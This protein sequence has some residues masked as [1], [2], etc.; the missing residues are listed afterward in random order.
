MV[1]SA[2][3]S[4]KQRLGHGKM[5]ANQLKIKLLSED[6]FGRICQNDAFLL[7]RVSGLARR[8]RRSY[9]PYRLSSCNGNGGF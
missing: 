7:T 4:I 5:R 8:P 2:L 1:V 9:F 6:G 3:A